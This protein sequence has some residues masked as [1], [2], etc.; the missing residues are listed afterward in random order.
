MDWKRRLGKRGMG[1]GKHSGDRDGMGWE[2]TVRKER[3]GIGVALCFSGEHSRDRMGERLETGVALRF[4]GEHRGIE[5]DVMETVDTT[6]VLCSSLERLDWVVWMEKK[7]RS[8]EDW[9]FVWIEWKGWILWKRWIG[10]QE[11]K[12]G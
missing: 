7:G 9:R 11:E 3:D 4:S 6:G 1:S 12:V 5:W 10:W 8:G 2:E